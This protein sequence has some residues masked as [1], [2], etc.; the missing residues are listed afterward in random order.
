MVNEHYVPQA[1]L[2]FFAPEGE[3]LIS[4]Y[5]LVEKH[6]GG[7][8]KSPNNRYSVRNAASAEGFANG[9]LETDAT[10]SAEKR[11]VRSLEK[12]QKAKELSEGDIA[13]ISKFIGLQFSR[14]PDSKLHFDAR[15][16]LAELTGSEIDQYWES[17]VKH[18]ADEAYDSLQFMG[19]IIVENESNT[20][21]VTS[22]VSVVNYFDAD[23]EEIDGH[24]FQFEQRQIFF[25]I[26][27]KHQL[28]LLDPSHFQ[29]ESQYPH[30][31]VERTSITDSK[32]I[33]K[34]NLLQGVT[35]FQEIFGPV[36]EGE[37]LEDTIETLC[38]A[39]PDEDYIRG[40]RADLGTIQKAQDFASGGIETQEDLAWYSE[41]GKPL[42]NSRTKKAKALW[43]FSHSISMID[44]LYR[45]SPNLS[46]WDDLLE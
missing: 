8:Y 41:K 35:A 23:R 1:Y 7:D 2:R 38:D 10:T 33:H 39:F 9:F 25:P 27:P 6:G 42:I 14:T 22:D 46:Y 34:F 3:G 21:I 18:N 5:S 15:E 12:L 43:N 28:L 26:G 45:D 19:W 36:D 30:T 29:I 13:I 44:D 17:T 24:S 40:N 4:R 11:M 31:E 16:Q 32:E 37:L 20:P